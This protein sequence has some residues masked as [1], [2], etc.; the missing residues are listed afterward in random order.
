MK[1]NIIK[2]RDIFKESHFPFK[3]SFISSRIRNMA[4]LAFGREIIIKA[5]SQID[6]KMGLK[7]PVKPRAIRPMQKTA[8][9]AKKLKKRPCL[10]CSNGRFS[11]IYNPVDMFKSI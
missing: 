8:C 11:M 2:I 9:P 7:K 4:F 6:I 5:P 1:T 10:F 3:K